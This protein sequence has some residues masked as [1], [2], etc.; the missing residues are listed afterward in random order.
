MVV[1]ITVLM[2]VQITVLMVVQITVL[3]T[4]AGQGVQPILLSCLLLHSRQGK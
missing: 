3:T 4:D 2:V 1:Q